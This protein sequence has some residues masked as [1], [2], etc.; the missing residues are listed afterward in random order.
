VFV[1]GC[2]NVVDNFQEVQKTYTHVDTILDR[3]LSLNDVDERHILGDS[4]RENP[5]NTRVLW[6]IC[7]ICG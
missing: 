2:G 1:Q 3:Q 4:S 6:I 5:S 7:G